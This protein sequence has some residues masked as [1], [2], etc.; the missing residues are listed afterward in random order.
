MLRGFLA[1]NSESR[2]GRAACP[3]T[4]SA[5]GS[6]SPRRRRLPCYKCKQERFGED[7]LGTFIKAI[8]RRLK[9]TAVICPKRNEESNLQL[10]WHPRRGVV[11]QGKQDG[12]ILTHREF[13]SGKVAAKITLPFLLT[14][15]TCN[16]DKSG[17]LSF[18]EASQ[19][20]GEETHSSEAS[21]RRH[22]TQN[23]DRAPDAIVLFG[24]SNF[25][26]RVRYCV[27]FGGQCN[28]Y[29]IVQRG[30]AVSSQNF[31]IS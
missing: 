16:H 28:R 29:S 2:G 12:T 3:T 20:G 14:S 15:S 30:C 8:F 6:W 31:I 9:L 21:G 25:R 22:S 27:G 18:G 10:L 4:S 23:P 11:P 19:T 26:R 24:L 13:C 17:P 1:K 5:V 7:L